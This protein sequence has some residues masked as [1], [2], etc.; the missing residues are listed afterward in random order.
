M[1]F[2]NTPDGTWEPLWVWRPTNTHFASGGTSPL[3]FGNRSAKLE[4]Q[5]RL[6]PR[7]ELDDATL[8]KVAV[9][10]AVGVVATLAAAK[11]APVLMRRLTELRSRR[12][13]T[14]LG[15]GPASE[16]E[17]SGV[18][19]R[20]EVTSEEFTSEV[21]AALAERRRT[22]SSAEAEQRLLAVLMAAAFIA[23][24]VRALSNSELG[25]DPDSQVLEQTMEKLSTPQVIDSIN[26]M[27]ESGPSLVDDET[28]SELMKLFGGGRLV[29]GKYVPLRNDAVRHA[30]RLRTGDQ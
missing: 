30:L 12:S 22:M 28:A 6:G 23:D 9:G 4:G 8:V 16:S 20:S 2:D 15:S 26:R 3:A 1:S 19:V 10:V 5:A 21:N 11:T 27:I 7:V 14:A 25:D 13:R 17:T 29:D 18:A 24:Q